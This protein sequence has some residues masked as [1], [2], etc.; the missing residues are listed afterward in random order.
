VP[1]TNTKDHYKQ[2]DIGDWTYGEP[3][4]RSFYPGEQLKIGKFCSI[5]AGVVLLFGGD[6]NSRMISTYP[7]GIYFT[8]GDGQH[9]HIAMRG[10]LTIG[11]DV[12]IGTDALIF[13]GTTI[14]NGAVIGA[15]SVVTRDVLPYEVVGGTPAHHIRL[16]F[17]PEIIEHLERIAWWNWPLEKIR[18]ALPLMISEDIQSFVEAYK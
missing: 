2:Y 8:G 15:R 3:E 13:A 14:G 18:A 4:I 1:Y 7:L 11:N 16:R 6:H 9:S 12:W 5:A 10:D 17:T